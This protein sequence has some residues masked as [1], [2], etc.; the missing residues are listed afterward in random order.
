MFNYRRVIFPLAFLFVLLTV[1]VIIMNDDAT[2]EGA[3]TFPAFATH[4]IAGNPVTDEIL[5]GSP[6]LIC[7]WIVKD[8]DTSRDLLTK[9]T[10]MKETTSKELRF[11][12][13]VGDLR[14][15][16]TDATKTAAACDIAAVCPADFPQLA[17]NDDL[18]EFLITIHSAP[19]ICFTDANGN[20]IGQPVVGNDITLIQKEAARVLEGNSPRVRDMKNVQKAIFSRP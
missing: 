7:L 15:E 14:D 5:H 17:V 9:L 16:T 4:D 13:L 11:V 12:G 3:T 8:A 6:T 20:L 18:R 10:L 1:N 2:P 19:T